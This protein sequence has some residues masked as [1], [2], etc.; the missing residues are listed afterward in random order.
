[1]RDDGGERK[2]NVKDNETGTIG[3]RS[4]GHNGTR[5]DRLQSLR[6]QRD[7]RS[8]AEMLSFAQVVSGL[9]RLGHT[10]GMNLASFAPASGWFNRVRCPIAKLLEASQRCMLDFQ[11]PWF[12]SE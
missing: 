2:T 9:E 4:L 1:M 7:V 3:R 12:R 6:E 11:V 5:R 8:A 10:V